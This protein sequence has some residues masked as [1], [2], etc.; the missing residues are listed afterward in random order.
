VQRAIRM[1]HLCIE[2]NYLRSVNIATY[3]KIME[4]S[5]IWFSPKDKY[6]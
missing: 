4:N 3:L 6:V 5:G 2:E 1:V